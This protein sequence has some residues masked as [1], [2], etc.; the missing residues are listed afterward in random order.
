VISTE[1]MRMMKMVVVIAIVDEYENDRGG[2]DNDDNN[3]SDDDKMQ[4]WWWWRRR[5]W[6]CAVNSNEQT[7]SYGRT[8]TK[9]IRF[10]G[11]SDGNVRASARSHVSL[12]RGT[13]SGCTAVHA[14]VNPS[15]TSPAIS[16]IPTRYFIAL[17][18]GSAFMSPSKICVTPRDCFGSDTA[19]HSSSTDRFL[20]SSASDR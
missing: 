17:S 16:S 7:N 12:L 8:K 14:S 1:K 9:S 4:L 20:A 19:R 13:G 10:D 15:T 2:D 5:R 18:C 6:W 11:A 3:D